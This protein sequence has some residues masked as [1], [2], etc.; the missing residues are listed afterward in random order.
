M[1]LLNASLLL[2]ASLLT[3]CTS[4]K[5]Y[6]D[7]SFARTRYE[8]LKRPSK[9][10]TLKVNAEFLRNGQRLPKGDDEIRGSVERTLRGSG[11][12]IPSESGADGEIIVSV[13]N[14]G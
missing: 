10:L 14:V 6:V 12:I 5:S 1:K 9:P 3:A 11:L 8:E 7:A 4:V 13:N 2:V